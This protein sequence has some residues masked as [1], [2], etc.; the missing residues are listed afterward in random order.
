VDRLARSFILGLMKVRCQRCSQ[1]KH[2]SLL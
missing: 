1:W 2:I